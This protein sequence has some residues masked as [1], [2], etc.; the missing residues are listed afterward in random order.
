MNSYTRRSKFAKALQYAREFDIYPLLRPMLFRMDAETAHGLAIAALKKGLIPKARHKPDPI[1]HTQLY[2]LSFPNPVGLA[3][4]FD[5][6]AEVMGEL[7]DLDFGFVEIGTIT[8]LPQTGNS[9]PRLFRIPQVEAVINRFGFNSD[10]NETCGRRVAAWRDTR[11]GNRE[12]VLGINVGKNKDSADAAADY[13]AGIRAFAPHADYLVVNIS[14]PNTPG[15]RD[16]QR[17]E[18]MTALLAQVI[19]A[20]DSVARKVPVLV[21]I[22]PDQ[23][24]AQEEDIAAVALASGIDGMIIGNTTIS[25]PKEIPPE[26]AKEAGGLSGKPLGEMSTQ[27]IARMYKRLGGKIP[28]IG[29]GGIS[30]G[31]DAYAKIRA[32]AALVQLYTA[33]VYEGPRL[34]PHI[35]RDLAALLRRDGF[36][37]VSEAVGADHRQ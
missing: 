12:K 17:R 23:T 31:A 1:L 6:Q 9:K 26:L 29:C 35:N 32:G 5:K 18:E 30:N 19:A 7:F 24:A 28:I 2:G 10:G 33:L 3:A 25:R 21:K 8:P 4:G 14:S 16:L 37:S 20:R 27:L 36:A 34:V 13:T 11:V 22:A 15:L